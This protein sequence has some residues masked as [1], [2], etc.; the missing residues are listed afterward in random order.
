[1]KKYVAYN[2]KK[3]AEAKIIEMNRNLD[4]VLKAR[5]KTK[6]Y[7]ET[8]VKKDGKFYVGV[9]DVVYERFFTTKQLNNSIT[10]LWRDQ[11]SSV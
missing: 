7:Q 3:E 6:K 9:F 10:I 4:L 2:T 1:M 5:S 11:A 8:P